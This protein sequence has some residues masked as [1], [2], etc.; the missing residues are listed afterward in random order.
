MPK[1]KKPNP[2]RTRPEILAERIERTRQLLST[3]SPK[4]QI[5]KA[6]RE[7]FG[8]SVRTCESYITQ[9]REILLAET[10]KS[11]QEHTADAY[12][13]YRSV[14]ESETTSTAEKLDATKGIVKLFGLE[15]ARKHHHTGEVTSAKVIIRLPDN[16]REQ[17]GPAAT[18]V[19]NA[20]SKRGTN[21]KP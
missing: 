6:L 19:T 4:Y 13:Y 14:L 2:G 10:S 16:G 1:K 21:G 20:S 17:R 11:R 5:K 8:I 9:A 7:E 12:A 18:N 3:Q 15:E